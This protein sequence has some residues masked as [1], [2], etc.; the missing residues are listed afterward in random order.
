MKTQDRPTITYADRLDI[1]SST[2]IIVTQSIGHNSGAFHP[3]IDPGHIDKSV[4]GPELT[5]QKPG[6]ELK[7]RVRTIKQEI[8]QVHQIVIGAIKKIM[9]LIKW[10]SKYKRESQKELMVRGKELV[11]Y[12]SKRDRPFIDRHF[13][14]FFENFLDKVLSGDSIL[15]IR[16]LT[17]RPKLVTK[18]NDE[19]FLIVVLS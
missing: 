9:G 1:N 19:Y 3:R 6:E 10:K 14:T 11:D 2:R 5:Q 7:V 12:L 17:F 18:K 16:H 15:S 13:S 4:D 8:K